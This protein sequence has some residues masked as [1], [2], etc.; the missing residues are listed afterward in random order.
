MHRIDSLSISGFKSFRSNVTVSFPGQINAIVGPNGCGKSN[1]CDA[2]LWVLGEQ[3]ARVLRGSRMEDVIFNG[4]QRHGPL[5]L[6]E[7]SLRLKY[8]PDEPEEGGTSLRREDIE[9]S[10]R[11]FRDG[12]S[13]YYLNGRRC[14]LLDIQEAFEGTGLGFTSYAL[15]EQGRIQNILSSKPLDKRALIE[16]AARIVSFKHRKKSALL[17]LEM[18]QA[19]LLRIRDIIVEIE[20]NLKTLRVQVQK[21]KRYRQLREQMRHFLRVRFCLQG[22][23]LRERLDVVRGRHAE[24][25]GLAAQLETGLQEKQQRLGSEKTSLN[26]QEQAG[27]ALGKEL[28]DLQVYLERISTSQGYLQQERQNQEER[29]AGNGLDRER[30]NGRLREQLDNR[31]ELEGRARGLEGELA[32][33]QER[34]QEASQSAESSRLR[35]SEQEKALEEL[36]RVTF[37]E[38]G[39]LSRIR[40]QEVTLL[41]QQRWGQKQV[42][43]HQEDLAG[44]EAQTEKQRTALEES[45]AQL[46]GLLNQ[47]EELELDRD[48]FRSD[49]E[50][51]EGRQASLR[52]RL[53]EMEKDLDAR[54]H[55]LKSLEELE[56]RYEF[57]SDALKKFLPKLSGHPDYRGT[58]AD[59]LESGADFPSVAEGFLRLEL[60]TVVVD[61]EELLRQGIDLV[62][63]NR[64]GSCQFLLP[65]LGA[66]P[67]RA[68]VPQSPAPA[69]VVGRLREMFLLDPRGE[70]LLRRMVPDLDRVWLAADWPAAIEWVRRCPGIDCLSLDGVWVSHTGRVVVLGAVPSKGVLGYRH[71]QKEIRRSLTEAE[72]KQVS[73]QGELNLVED[74]LEALNGRVAELDD[75]I[76]QA[77]LDKVH[78]QGEI[79]RVSDEL[80]RYENLTRTS[81]LE[82]ET[83]QQEM[84]TAAAEL[85]RI[86]TLIADQE[87][88]RQEK[89]AAFERCRAEIETLKEET[90]RLQKNSAEAQL[91]LT[92]VKGRL[93]GSR[94]E[95]ARVEQAIGDH[96]ARLAQLEEERQSLTRRLDEI[97]TEMAAF[98][99]S[100]RES[101]S[102]KDRLAK[103]LAGQNLVIAEIKARISLWEKEIEELRS[104]VESAWQDRNRTEI[105]K[106][107]LEG[108]LAHLE[109]N[110]VLEFHASLQALLDEPDL[111][112]EGLGADAAYQRYLEYRDRTEKLGEVNLLAVEEYDQEEER[113]AFHQAQEKD[114]TDSIEATQK[115]IQEI[116]QRSARLFRETFGVINQNFQEMFTFLFGGGFCEL[117]LV[118]EENPLESG[119]DIVAS[120]PGKKLQ[121]LLLLSG[122]EKALTALALLL[123]IFKYRPSPFCIMDEV[124]APL[125]ESNIERFVSLVKRMSS[126]TQYILITHNKRTMEIAETIYGV[127]ME[128]AGVSKVLSMHL[129]DLV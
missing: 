75:S 90:S 73:L 97:G 85:A 88:N 4:T 17:K 44:Y 49:L 27:Q 16:E 82:L 11:M 28:A 57:Y 39:T 128:E 23:E 86:Q 63:K 118:D 47:L 20:R 26:R 106:A 38:A 1:V 125:D 80:R 52:G 89:Q 71:E 70:D 37:E 76:Q 119:V 31:M 65:E 102:Q 123:A 33:L 25:A 21:A 95:L 45:E 32:G 110:C 69:K 94:S 103:D 50:L 43:R 60:E 105:E 91:Q 114:I 14:R 2:F 42:S 10:R 8:L 100:A 72:S 13:E 81:R 92:T 112:T 9:I 111:D 101:L 87:T 122:G 66:A 54:R 104:Q 40:N 117:R 12:N 109:E 79:K 58:L 96:Q 3:S 99:E 53:Q 24:L 41:E 129:K 7:V 113:L 29:L 59:Q 93:A 64:A 5:S 51:L 62:L 74:E 56:A 120:P 98:G 48:G 15:I 55:R 127:T 116:D 84:E 36:R 30:L 46:A 68:E 19:N 6:S 126:Q 35:L 67:A 18:A 121:N 124:D 78:Q 34:F 77:R 115:G 83:Q 22:R 61:S 108:E 107:R